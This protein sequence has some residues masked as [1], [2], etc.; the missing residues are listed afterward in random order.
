MSIFSRLLLSCTCRGVELQV[1]EAPHPV[2]QWLDELES[3]YEAEIMTTLQ[4]KSLASD[5]ARQVTNMAVTTS[6]TVRQLHLRT[7]TISME[8]SKLSQ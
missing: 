7:K 4:S 5:L 2:A 6:D 8:L 1:G 3:V